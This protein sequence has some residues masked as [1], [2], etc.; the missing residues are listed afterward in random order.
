[1][2]AGAGPGS[3]FDLTIRAVAEA[4]QDAHLVDVPLTVENRPGRSGADQLA[5]M[6]E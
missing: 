5:I 2:T 1:M 4:L 6:V 3:G